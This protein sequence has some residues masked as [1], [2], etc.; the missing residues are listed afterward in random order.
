MTWWLSGWEDLEESERSARR[1]LVELE[2]EVL[3]LRAK[4]ETESKT[5][6]KHILPR[7]VWERKEADEQEEEQKQRSWLERI[8]SYLSRKDSPSEAL[9]A[10]ATNLP[11]PAET[12]LQAADAS[13]KE[14]HKQI[15][16]NEKQKEHEAKDY[17]VLHAVKS[18]KEKESEA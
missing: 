13:I 2:R 10:L 6:L 16:E 4:N 14:K 5:P 1:A 11:G 15:E 12:I 3:R 17:G 9:E 18:K 7:D 8:T